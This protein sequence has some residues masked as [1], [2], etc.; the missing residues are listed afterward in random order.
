MKKFFLISM[1]VLAAISLNAQDKANAE[2][3]AAKK[4]FME[5]KMLN[6]KLNDLHH[7]LHLSADQEAKFDVIYKQYN[8]EMKGTFG[9]RDGK[10]NQADDI[11]AVKKQIKDRLDNAKNAID[12]Q[13]KYIDEFA[14]VLN[15]NQLRDFP[16][17]EKKLQK[18]LLDRKLKK[19]DG[20]RGGPEGKGKRHGD[21]PE[22]RPRHGAMPGEAPD[23]I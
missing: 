6:A 1:T 7:A 20:K 3:K 5:E 2:D 15:A 11:E 8:V 16:K 19:R 22:R 12:I 21:R 18:K 14:T 23:A 4:A 9:K 13:K 10:K 17:V